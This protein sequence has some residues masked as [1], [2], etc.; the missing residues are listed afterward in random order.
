M[1]CMCRTPGVGW[2]YTV[3][4]T[5]FTYDKYGMSLPHKEKKKNQY[6]KSLF[7]RHIRFG[8]DEYDF[9]CRCSFAP[10]FAVVVDFSLPFRI[11]EKRKR[12]KR[13]RDENIFAWIFR[14]LHKNRRRCNDFD[15]KIMKNDPF[16]YSIASYCIFVQ[17]WNIELC[18]IWRT[19]AILKSLIYCT[20]WMWIR[21][22]EFNQHQTFQLA[23]NERKTLTCIGV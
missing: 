4:G 3:R 21:N 2:V 23:T 11:F 7:E 5:H 13:K 12:K 6:A 16:S 17:I 14:W 10:Y 19:I 15:F 8:V 1:A 20:L 18:P 9:S 22:L